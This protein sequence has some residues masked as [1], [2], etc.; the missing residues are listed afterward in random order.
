MENKNGIQGE[1]MPVNKDLVGSVMV[2]GGGPAGLEAAR[3]AALRG[4]EVTLYDKE[5]KTGGQFNIA[6]VPPFKQEL[7]KVIKYLNVQIEKSGVR[8]QLN[9]DVN[10]ELVEKIKPD[11]VIVATG[12]EPVVP[13]IP[14]IDGDKVVTAHDVLAGK[15]SIMPGKVLVI[16]GGMVGCETAEH[17]HKTGDNPLIGRTGVTVIEMLNDVALDISVESRSLLLQRMRKEGIEILTSTK[18]KE[19]LKDGVLVE[20]EGKDIFIRNVD[21]I[22]LGIG[23]RSVDDL[24]SALKEKVDEV[25]VIGDAKQTRNILPAIVEGTEVGRKI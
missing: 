9:T 19:F 16:G 23:A 24:S 7:C 12:G 13:D 10:L 5:V 6:A 14:G 11:V 8:V 2:V 4:H 20:K 1:E 25:Y 15:V 21:L 18:V 22:V 3:V 17:M